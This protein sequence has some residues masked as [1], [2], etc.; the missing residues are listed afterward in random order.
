[1]AKS[2]SRVVEKTELPLKTS[3]FRFDLP[4]DLIAQ[5]PAQIRDASRL[6]VANRNSGQYSHHHFG[7][8]TQ[9]LRKGDVLVLNDSRVLPA[10]LRGNKIE[11]AATV[12][13]LLT[14][15]AADNTW[16]AL[17]KPGKRLPVGS[18]IAIRNRNGQSTSL[19]AD[20]LEKNE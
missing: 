6:L 5:Q 2:G 1:M 10:R 15:P 8:L 3:D 7:D 4:H 9:L 16:W 18:R 12:E 20:V 17:V 13:L 14:E 19:I 11:G